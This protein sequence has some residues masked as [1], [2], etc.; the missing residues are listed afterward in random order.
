MDLPPSS[1]DPDAVRGLAGR[2]LSEARYDRPPES[3][4]E[5]IQ[6]WF[7]DRIADLLSTLVG[8][9]AGTVVA[10]IVVLGAIG[11][12]V[13]LV[14]RHGRIVD[15]EQ[16]ERAGPS[17]MV[18][19]S[20]SPAQWLS[21]ADAL[22]AAG[23]WKEALRCRYRALVAD[24]VRRGAIAD[25]PGRTAREYVG[26]VTES[27]PEAATAMADATELFEAAWYG[28]VPTGPSAAE[29]F[30]ELTAEILDPPKPRRMA[31]V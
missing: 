1:H 27:R 30:Q 24:L 15:L 9:G 19:L 13:Y 7:A 11:A 17:A 4:A 2:I 8:S 26:D 14:I 29:R 18:E 21:E 31:G 5:R 3:L 6:G 10:W 25:Q 16:P 22:E 28:D 23:R 12:V 20:R